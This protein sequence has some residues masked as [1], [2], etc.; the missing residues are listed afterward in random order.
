MANAPQIGPFTKPLPQ[1]HLEQA[2]A[3]FKLYREFSGRPQSLDWAAVFLFYTL[4]HLIDAYFK[5][6]NG[7]FDYPKSH[8]DRER[9]INGSLTQIW[10]DY[11]FVF[12]RANK[13][14][15]H[16]EEAHPT[17][18]QLHTWENKQFKAVVDE[19]KKYYQFELE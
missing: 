9:Y 15:Y 1:Q 16:P 11:F 4:V 13:A 19:L 7:P 14:R 18:A 6:R 2:K 10:N 3:N 12:N 8:N 5:E 17:F